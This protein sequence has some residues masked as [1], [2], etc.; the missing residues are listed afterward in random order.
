MTFDV[1]QIEIADTAVMTVKDVFGNELA[2]DGEAVTIEL[3]SP[4]SPQGVKAL[5]KSGRGAQM[6]Q[7]RMMR[8]QPDPNDAG[9]ADREYAQKLA[10]FTKAISPNLPLAPFD[11]YSNPKLGYISVQVAEFISKPANFSKGSSAT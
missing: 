1:S 3:Y 6:R 4:G 8:E 11:I 2:I 9:N 5:H 7:W 10:D